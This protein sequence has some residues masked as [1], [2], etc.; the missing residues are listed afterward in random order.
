MRVRDIV[1]VVAEINAGRPKLREVV[2]ELDLPRRLRRR[3]AVAKALW[4]RMK[5]SVR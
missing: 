1:S 5:E 3:V 4:S 2:Q